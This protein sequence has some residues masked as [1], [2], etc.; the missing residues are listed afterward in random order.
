ME[1]IV[2][3]STARLS[4]TMISLAIAAAVA[5]LLGGIGLYGVLSYVVNQR[6]QEMGVRMALGAETGQVLWMVV[7]QGMMVVGTGLVMGIAASL[8]LGRVLEACSMEPR[9]T[10][11]SRSSPLP[12]SCSWWAF[13]QATCRPG[14]R[15]PSILWRP[16]EPS[17]YPSFFN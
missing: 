15:R 11:L 9:L 2:A 13:W 1:T 10:I 8:Y 5:L 4:F 3:D 17:S 14:E 12:G 6:T 7:R 16:S